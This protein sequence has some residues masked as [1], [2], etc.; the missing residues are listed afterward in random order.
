M[1]RRL[2]S[3]V[4]GSRTAVHLHAVYQVTPAA[5]STVFASAAACSACIDALA[6]L[7][8]TIFFKHCLLILNFTKL[9]RRRCAI[10]SCCCDSG[11]YVLLEKKKSKFLCLLSFLSARQ[12]ITLVAAAVPAL[13]GSLRNQ[14]LCGNQLCPV[15][16]DEPT[17][18]P[19]TPFQ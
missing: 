3:G 8:G 9:Q 18:S 12:F 4:K 17:Q 1:Y 11:I 5:S 13:R 15:C 10:P 6:S 2:I 14:R 7:S 19:P 16:Q